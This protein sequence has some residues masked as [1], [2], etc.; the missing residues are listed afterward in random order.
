MD[1]RLVFLRY[2]PPRQVLR[3]M[4]LRGRQAITARL[5]GS[6][7]EPISGE[8]LRPIVLTGLRSPHG[9]L[10]R[11]DDGWTGTF[12]N[13]T[14]TIDNP[15]RWDTGSSDSRS[16]LWRMNLHYF[17]YIHDLEPSVAKALILDWI[18]GNRPS[19]PNA[20]RAA[21]ASYTIS[22]RL[23]A[24]LDWWSSGGDQ[25]FDHD[26]AAMVAASVRE[27]ANHLLVHIETDVRGNHL[28]KNIRA[29][30]ECSQAL[31]CR[32]SKHWNLVALSH[33]NR[34]LPI[35]ILDDG[36]HFERSLSY[37][38]QV[39]ADLLSVYGNIDKPPAVLRKALERMAAPLAD[40]WHPDGGPVQ[41]N[42]SGLA[43]AVRA[44]DAIRAYADLLGAPPPKVSQVF[45][46]SDAGFFGARRDS[47]YVL[48]KMGPLGPDALMAHAHGDWGT[49][50]FSRG[51]QRVFVDQGVFEYV[52]GDK[53]HRSRST[54]SHN[55]AT[56]DGAEQA[57]FFGAFR[58]GARPHPEAARFVETAQGFELAG[59][60]KSAPGRSVHERRIIVDSDGLRIVDCSGRQHASVA[61]RLLLHPDVSAHHP[62]KSEMQLSLP[63]GETLL[64]E[65]LQGE[66]SIEPAVWWPDMGIEFATARL[67]VHGKGRTEIVVRPHTALG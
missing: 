28:I 8:R 65:A 46:Y 64:I 6:P 67:I 22:L 37:H 19:A 29:L 41:M 63:S 9:T 39:F 14:R 30:I 21:W 11:S 61:S 25:L 10:Q 62:K 48:V 1:R 17:E 7:L 42:D 45:S 51:E 34:E 50:E 57:D 18:T 16:Q 23:S 24:W 47:N 27:Q 2:T 43:M 56:I 3:R 33:L 60:I 44:D 5:S 31:P 12:L 13:D 38:A 20:F 32:D 58:C 35:Q 36:G 52:D 49:L 4:W 40:L 59:R 54:A 53:R 15:I 55:T 26:D 66:M